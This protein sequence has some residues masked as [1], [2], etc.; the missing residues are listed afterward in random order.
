MAQW[1]GLAQSK[2]LYNEAVGELVALGAAIAAN[3]QPCFK[4][5]HAKAQ[6]LGISEDDMTS[7]VN[8]AMAVKK[9]AERATLE[10]ADQMLSSADSKA[11]EAGCGCS[12]Q[13]GCC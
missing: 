1:A 12:S 7:A 11:Q 9:M 6:A 10:L 5:H 8:T 3:C 13:S 2:N 4:H